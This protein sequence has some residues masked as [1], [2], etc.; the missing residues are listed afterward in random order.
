MVF[1]WVEIVQESRADD[2]QNLQREMFFTAQPH[3]K[4][5]RKNKQAHQ[6]GDVWEVL[7]VE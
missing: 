6:T 2:I 7:Y 5:Q 1:Q 3:A 4:E